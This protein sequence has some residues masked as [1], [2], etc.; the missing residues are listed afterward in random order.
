MGRLARVY[1]GGLQ[2]RLNNL[3]ESGCLAPRTLAGVFIRARRDM[4]RL[5]IKNLDAAT[6]PGQSMSVGPD[7]FSAAN[8]YRQN[9]DFGFESHA[10]GAGLEFLR[11]AIRIAASAFGENHHRAALTDP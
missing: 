8:R 11:R 3:R 6:K 4:D 9:Y 5:V 1:R 2:I 10:H 7:A